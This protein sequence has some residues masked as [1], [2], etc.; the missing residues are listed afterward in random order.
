MISSTDDTDDSADERTLSRV[1]CSA[2]R[3]GGRLRRSG[4]L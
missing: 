1:A 3:R 4:G 2:R